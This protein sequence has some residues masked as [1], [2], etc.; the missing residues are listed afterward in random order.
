MNSIILN[1][2]DEVITDSK[3]LAH[4]HE[5]LKLNIGDQV[6]VTIL[7]SG[8]GIATVHEL[9]NEKLVLK[10]GNIKKAFP[11]WIDLIVG[12]S[13]PQ[14]MKKVLEHGTTFGVGH[15]HFY[16]AEL[17][18]KS[19]LDSKLFVNNEFNEFTK[20]G[21]S[22]STIFDRMPKVKT[23]KYNPAKNFESISQKYI[24]DLNGAE[25]FLDTTIDFTQPIILSVG[26]ERGFT[27]YDLEHFTN[28]GFKS[29]KISSTVLRVENAIF[30]AIAQLEMLRNKI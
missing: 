9:T 15:F 10:M 2:I 21:L 18:E 17:S 14:T 8:I 6:K 25:T 11:Q 7:N 23:Y 19:Y 5:T 16:K 30:A 26:P 1:S 20:L 24:L 22:Q 12:V 27:P 28:A 29:I 13:R 3:T 4:I